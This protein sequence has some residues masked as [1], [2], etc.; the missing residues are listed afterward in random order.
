M[1]D[2][3]GGSTTLMGAPVT[4]V[5]QPAA[6]PFLITSMPDDPAKDD[7]DS[8]PRPL[9]SAS[10]IAQGRVKVARLQ[11][12]SS[13]E[14]VLWHELIGG[15]MALSR[16]MFDA[17]VANSTPAVVKTFPELDAAVAST[18]GFVSAAKEFEDRVQENLKAQFNLGLVDY[19]DLVTGSGPARTRGAPVA[20]TEPGKQTGR[21][22]PTL[23]PVF[24]NLGL[25]ADRAV[26]IVIGSFQGLNVSIKDL[27][28]FP[29]ATYSATLVYELRDHFGVDDDDCEISLQGFHGT[30]GQIA[31]WILQHDRR[32]GHVPYIDMA[33]VERKIR[34]GLR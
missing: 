6:T 18:P 9:K 23:E 15:D 28:V 7:L 2:P 20:R 13:L 17:W 1:P 25:L 22:L 12:D 8:T 33:T 30:P 3:I 5:A 24:P 34:G 10:I 26:K 4:M 21:M 16:T 19:R 32:P 11:P 14:R 27:K 31:M 29:D